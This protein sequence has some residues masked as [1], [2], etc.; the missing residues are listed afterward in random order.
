MELFFE[1]SKP[2]KLGDLGVDQET[3]VFLRDALR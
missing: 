1:H 3:L 2:E